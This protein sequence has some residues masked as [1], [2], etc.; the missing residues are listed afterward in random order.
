MQHSPITLEV[1]FRKVWKPL[2]QR[3][4]HSDDIRVKSYLRIILGH[5]IHTYILPGQ[6]DKTITS[7]TYGDT[8]W[9]YSTKKHS[10]WLGRRWGTSWTCPVSGCAGV[11][12]SSCPCTAPTRSSHPARAQCSLGRRWTRATWSDC[13]WSPRLEEHMFR[14]EKRGSWDVDRRTEIISSEAAGHGGWRREDPEIIDAVRWTA[15]RMHGPKPGLLS[16]IINK[17]SRW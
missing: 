12:W 7:M 2:L 11:C 3:L 14:L 17:W 13:C 15:E 5:P 16:Y 4:Y 9:Y 10:P 1:Y 8:Q 6:Q